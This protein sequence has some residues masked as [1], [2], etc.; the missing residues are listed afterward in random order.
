MA[1]YK[2]L[3]VPTRWVEAGR[4]RKCYHSPKHQVSKGDRVL[5]VKVKM[6]WYGY[7]EACAKQM[8][9]SAISELAALQ[10]FVGSAKP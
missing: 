9:R 2:S 1:A 5:E 6:A 8:L 3:I 10:T 4:S 7:C